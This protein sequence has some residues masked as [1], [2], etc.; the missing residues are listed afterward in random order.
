MDASTFGKACVGAVSVSVLRRRLKLARSS[1]S[2]ASVADP[3]LPSS[4]ALSV[5]S[6]PAGAFSF[7]LF[8]CHAATAPPRG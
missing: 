2:W 3:A 6:I 4:D 1:V 5:S 7:P 8:E